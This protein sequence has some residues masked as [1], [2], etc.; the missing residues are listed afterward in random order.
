MM[1]FIIKNKLLN[2][3]NIINLNSLRYTGTVLWCSGTVL[4]CPVVSCG[5]Q[6]HPTKVRF[7][8]S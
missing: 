3:K 1:Y 6:M 5:N 7:G 8:K 2:I 4:G